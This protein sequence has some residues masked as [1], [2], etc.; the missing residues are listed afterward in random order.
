MKTPI[1]N[2]FLY[3]LWTEDVTRYDGSVV[4]YEF[5]T[6]KDTVKI[7]AITESDKFVVLQSSQP[8]RGDYLDMPGWIIDEGEDRTQAA[9]RELREETWMVSDEISLFWSYPYD[10][11]WGIKYVALMQNCKKIWPQ[12]LD[13]WERVSV[14]EVEREEFDR[15]VFSGE[16][17]S[18][19]EIRYEWSEM[20]RAANY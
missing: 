12:S 20:K 18:A 17:K 13:E 3:T 19:K 1:F 5:V 14:M 7:I 4:P 8:H 9:I 15:L 2:W 16:L 11:I 10:Y 6:L